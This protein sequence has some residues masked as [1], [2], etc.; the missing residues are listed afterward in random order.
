MKISL[1]NAIFKSKLEVLGSV[2]RENLMAIKVG[3]K[4]VDLIFL[5]DASSSVGE[6]N[7]KSEI[8]FVRKLLSDFPVSYNTTRVAIVTFSSN[9]KIVS[10]I[11]FKRA[12]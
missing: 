10:I 5:I 2:F 8:K 12:S 7:F 9:N 3:N 1:E 4:K 11:S 6:E